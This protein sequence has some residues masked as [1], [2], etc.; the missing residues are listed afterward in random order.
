[1]GHAK[2]TKNASNI[3]IKKTWKPRPLLLRERRAVAADASSSDRSSCHESLL[4][5]YL[6]QWL[7]WKKKNSQLPPTPPTDSI[8]MPC[9]LTYSLHTTTCPPPFSFH[10]IEASCVWTSGVCTRAAIP[11]PTTESTSTTTTTTTSASSWAK[12]KAGAKDKAKELVRPKENGIM[13]FSAAWTTAEHVSHDYYYSI[14]GK[15]TPIIYYFI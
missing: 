9:T 6:Q 1:M 15:A 12:E 5:R 2:T 10:V 3:I 8:I 7:E 13:D 14:C 11:T 4:R